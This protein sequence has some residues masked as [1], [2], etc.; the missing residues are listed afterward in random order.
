MQVAEHMNSLHFATVAVA[1]RVR[2]PRAA[3][4]EHLP[5]SPYTLGS[6]IAQQ[7]HDYVMHAQLGYYPPLD[8]LKTQN[9]VD[10]YLLDAAQH[11]AT[12][13]G[14]YVQQRLKEKLVPIFSSVRF[15]AL[16][17]HAFALPPIRPNQVHALEHLARH[18][19]PDVVK[20]DLLLSLVQKRKLEQGLE[21]YASTTVERLLTDTFDEF[22]ITSTRLV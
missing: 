21:H 20:C 7:A 13:S 3:L 1:L 18:Y 16:H 5:A 15:Q 9:I 19:T 22:E 4:M 12:V 10:G 2:V 11:V 8:Y 14:E 17:I 6:D